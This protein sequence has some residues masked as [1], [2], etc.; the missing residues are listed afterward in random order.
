MTAVAEKEIVESGAR[1]PLG[2]HTARAGARG[3]LDREQVLP[4]SGWE[5]LTER[6]SVRSGLFFYQHA[7]QEELDTALREEIETAI[8]NYVQRVRLVSGLSSVTVTE[9]RLLRERYYHGVRILRQGLMI[10]GVLF[11]LSITT[12]AFNMLVGLAGMYFSLSVLF[13]F[14]FVFWLET[15]MSVFNPRYLAA[16]I[17]GTIGLALSALILSFIA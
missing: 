15:K 9:G 14:V 10:F 3:V 5:T 13:F 17:V 2:T 7:L 1:K 12:T 11:L 8:D 6:P 4:I 16:G